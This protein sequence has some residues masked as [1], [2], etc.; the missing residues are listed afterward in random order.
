MYKVLLVDDEAVVLSGMK[1]VIDWERMGFE[2]CG[3]A[4]S[5]ILACKMIRERKPDLVITDVMMPGMTGIELAQ[6]INE[7]APE[8]EVMIV[9]GYDEF[10]YARS[11][12]SAGV[13]EYL[14][15]PT[16][17]NS[18]EM[19][20]TKAA[21]R[22]QRKKD[23][24]KD[25]KALKRE[26]SRSLEIRKNQFFCDLANQLYTGDQDISESLKEFGS[27]LQGSSWRLWAFSIDL[28]GEREFQAE[29]QGLLKTQLSMIIREGMAEDFRY[30]GFIQGGLSLFIVE[31]NE[32]SLED[33]TFLEELLAK[34]LEEYKAVTRRS[35]YVGVSGIYQDLLQL[36]QAMK[37]CEL[38][39]GAWHEECGGCV[40]YEESEL[41]FGE[42]LSVRQE[43]LV[44]IS[45]MVRTG[46][47]NRAMELTQSLYLEMKERR[48]NY[49]QIYSQS[50]LILTDL[51]SMGSPEARKTIQRFMGE[52]SSCKNT[53][54]I[55]DRIL[56]MIEDVA[57][58]DSREVCMKNE[59]IMRRVTEY[60]DKHLG[61]KISLTKMAE[62]AQ[63]SKNYFCSLFKKEKG[64]TFFAYLFRMRMERAKK[65]LKETDDKIYVIAD[66]VGYPDYFYF[67]RVFSKYVGVTA[68][69][70]REIYEGEA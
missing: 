36:P 31:N 35:A 10:D 12:M 40:F 32:D 27:E 22:M 62:Q 24:K 18:L 63:V 54:R 17:K 51:Y 5:G 65:L 46:N 43:A 50:I 52:L 3:T 39:L 56:R 20:L 16:D 9:S 1:T 6:W 8:T 64:E 26:A 69:E 58:C 48:M 38:A 60:V 45:E 29:Y 25:M 19:A 70:Y 4:D 53:D 2:I 21:G 59:E 13:S 14:L 68:S 28:P 33:L 57:D 30:D 66:M 44:Q 55:C 15:K 34:I 42:R 47:K 11:A 41:L 61:E 23:F 67:S 7:N 37:E 49:Q